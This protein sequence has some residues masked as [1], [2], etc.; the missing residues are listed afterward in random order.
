MLMHFAPLFMLAIKAPSNVATREW[1]YSSFPFFALPGDLDFS[2]PFYGDFDFPGDGDFA[3]G[4]FT[5]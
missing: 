2:F 4:G 5:F 1:T 3:L